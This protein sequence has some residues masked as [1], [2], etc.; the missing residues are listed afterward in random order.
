MLKADEWAVSSIEE[1]MRKPE[2]NYDAL[3]DEEDAEADKTPEGELPLE[4]QQSELPPK[5]APGQEQAS[6]VPIPEPSTVGMGAPERISKLMGDMIPYKGFL[7]GILDFCRA[8]H[9]L[10]ELDGWVA[11]HMAGRHAVYDGSA[12]CRMLTEAGALAKVCA[13]GSAY[14]E[15]DIEPQ[16][17]VKDGRKYLEPVEAPQAFWQITPDGVDAL[18]A[19]QPLKALADIF[20]R[21]RHYRSVFVQL[22]ELC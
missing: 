5:P 22:L 16:V 7:M 1:L 12:Y 3:A 14:D 15:A 17:V 8:P 10:A 6:S 21:E 4:D 2:D 20:E 9:T 13:D 19:Y 11:E 18:A